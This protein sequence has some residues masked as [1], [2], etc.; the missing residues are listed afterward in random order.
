MTVEQT[1]PIAVLDASVPI[2]YWSRVALRAL[3]LTEPPR[4][5][6]V[7]STAIVAEAWRILT[8]R[9]IA[10]D[11]RSATISRAAHELW[12]LLDPIFRIA[13]ASQLPKGAA[14]SPLRD[15][16]D[17][18]LWCAAIN[19]GARCIVSHSTRDFP[20]PMSLH[21][22]TDAGEPASLRHLQAGIEF[23]TAIEL[24]EDVIGADAA[25]LCGY[26]L[27]AGAAARSQRTPR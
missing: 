14:P 4:I 12:L 21:R 9:A 13:D 17:R 18:H 25:I 1:A 2:P 24:I 3:A 6:P 16:N 19:A 15:P 27:P 22:D 26:D 8:L 23:L 7:W 11:Q 20:L 10:A 5:I